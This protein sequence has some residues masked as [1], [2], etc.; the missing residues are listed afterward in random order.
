MKP[1]P[2][3]KHRPNEEFAHDAREIINDL[4]FEREVLEESVKHDYTTTEAGIVPLDRRRPAWHFAAI[5]LTLEAGF[6]ILFLGFQLYQAGL[7]FGRTVLY[8][9]LGSL[10]YIVYALAAAYLGA[11]SGQTHSLLSRSIFGVSGSGLISVLIFLGQMG[12][13]GFV[14]NLTAQLFGGLYGWSHILVIGVVLGVLMVFNN[15]FGFTG[16]ATYARYI[17]TPLLVVWVLYLVIHG[18]AQGN[19]IGFVP[20]ATAPLSAVAAISIVT[21]LAIWGAEPDIWRYGKPRFWWPALPLAFAFGFGMVLF[22][23]GGWIVARTSSSLDFGPAVATVT[24]LSLFGLSWLAFIVIL[25]TQVGINDGNYYESINALQN[26][27]GGWRHWKRTY[28]ALICAAGGGLAAW[29]IPYE[30]TNGFFKIAAF[31]AVGVPSATVIMA[32]DHFLVP[33]LFGISR[34]LT[35]VPAWADAGAINWPGVVALLIAVLFGA[36]AT[37]IIPGETAG[38]YWGLAPLETWV[39]AAVLYIAGVAIVRATASD[40]RS[41]LGFSKRILKADS[42]GTVPVDVVDPAPVEVSPAVS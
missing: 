21:S 28:S 5:W 27:A 20:K 15:L 7:G 4:Q 25:I 22:G 37:G 23:M 24:H 41:A 39:L 29:V 33:R 11:R 38:T 19:V 32:V 40:A 30:I 18:I 6:V 14:A 12:W 36:Y 42:V 3:L 2:G 34:P 10:V 13:A 1:D 31:V 26:L 9:I 16:V 8:L 17:V 35:R